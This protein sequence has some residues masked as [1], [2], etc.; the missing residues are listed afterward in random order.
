MINILKRLFGRKSQPQGEKM[1]GT[2]ESVMSKDEGKGK[3]E[4][5]LPAD[6]TISMADVVKRKNKKGKKDKGKKKIAEVAQAQ[7]I[8]QHKSGS[9]FHWHDDE[10]KLKA[11][12]AVADW[13]GMVRRIDKMEVV[14]YVDKANKTLITFTPFVENGVAD[15]A[16]SLEKVSVSDRLSKLLNLSGS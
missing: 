11:A 15:V 12:I 10:N 14:Q 9:E 13:Y 8:R 4:T 7:T 6:E 2:N 5:V 3:T 16:V 1:G